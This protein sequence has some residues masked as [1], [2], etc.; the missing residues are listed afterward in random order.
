MVKDMT[1]IP[2]RSISRSRKGQSLVEFALVVPILVLLMFGIAEFGRAWM[3]R[4][5]LTGAARE[6]VRAVV[7]WPGDEPAA[8]N[9]G[10]ALIPAGITANINFGTTTEA[11]GTV[12]RSAT[13][14]NNFTFSIWRIFTG[15][16]S[17][18]LA[19]SSTAKMRRE[20]TP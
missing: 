12:T 2:G 14:T 8:R 9:R 17:G 7:V 10:L 19:L 16:G 1:S 3:T 20:Y 4:N 5:I 11:N 18:S 6:A 13:A 15:L